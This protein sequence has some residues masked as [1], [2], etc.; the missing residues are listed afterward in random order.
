MTSKALKNTNSVREV[1]KNADC[2]LIDDKKAV[3][4]GEKSIKNDNVKRV[5]SRSKLGTKNA[6]K[7]GYRRSEPYRHVVDLKPQLP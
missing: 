5:S 7:E 2:H 4:L 3:F 1:T 6:S